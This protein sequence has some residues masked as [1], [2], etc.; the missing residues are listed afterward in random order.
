MISARALAGQLGLR[1]L[2]RVSQTSRALHLRFA[3]ESELWL[4]SSGAGL[5]ALAQAGSDAH[6]F[7][8]AHARQLGWEILTQQRNWPVPQPCNP[9]DWL[10]APAHLLPALRAQVLHS[11]HIER[12]AGST[13]SVD[14]ILVQHPPVPMP[15][16][17]TA[18]QRRFVLFSGA[19]IA[20]SSERLTLQ[21]TQ[22]DALLAH[23][24]GSLCLWIKPE[25]DA[26]VRFSPVKL[27][28]LLLEKLEKVPRQQFEESSAYEHT[29]DSAKAHEPDDAPGI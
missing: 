25:T 1:A 8:E 26:P 29:V 6:R 14:R 23:S 17:Q 21:I 5:A 20:R 12:L 22:L 24:P 3:D 15:R 11:A 2:I 10:T 19:C 16:F 13:L 4:S 27:R 28:A 9:G 7:A 18:P